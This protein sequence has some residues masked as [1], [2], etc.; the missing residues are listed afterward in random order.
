M[1]FGY[2]AA[3]YESCA[4]PGRVSDG[5]GDLGGRSYGAIQ[6]AS[7]AGSVDEFLTWLTRSVNRSRVIIG[8]ELKQFPVNSPEFIEI[9]KRIGN[10]DNALSN[11]FLDAQMEYG[12]S[13]YYCPAA[14]RLLETLDF[15]ASQY[16]TAVRE[17]IYSRSVQYSAFWI[18]DLFESAAQLSGKPLEAMSDEDIIVNVYQVLINDGEKALE[19]DNGFWHSPDDWVNGSRDV[20]DGLLNRF[21]NERNDALILLKGGAID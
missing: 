17:V 9:W 1:R 13:V 18:K 7:N 3:K 4:D 16:S 8:F 10:Y 2:L 5:E 12:E 15:D 21:N 6:F 14:K 19:G 11:E 20:V